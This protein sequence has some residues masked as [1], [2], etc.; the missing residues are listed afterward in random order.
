MAIIRAI[1]K[2]MII[3]Y[4]LCSTIS[5]KYST[6]P[7]KIVID[8][9]P[10]GDD[11]LAIMLAVM[12]EAQ[13]REIEILAITGT[14][15]NT[16][17]ENVENNL[18]KILTVANKKVPVYIGSKKPLIN[19]YE[20][21]YYFGKDGFGDFNFT[22]KITAKVDRSKHAS[23]ALVDLVKQYPGEITV[24]TLGPLTTIATAI[25]LEPNFLHLTKQHIM[26]GANIKRNEAEFNF[27]QDPE[28]DWIVLNNTNK[29][30]IILPIETVHSHAFS[31]D[32]YRSLCSSMDNSIAS[33]LYQAERKALEKQNNTWLPADGIT[34]AIALQPDIIMRSFKTNLT[35]VLVG[36]A[37]GS[38]VANSDSQ[39]HN[40][41]IIEYFDKAAFKRLILKLL[42]K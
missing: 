12:H 8:T 21:E 1:S 18:L 24:V 40:A 36:D 22:E 5:Q 15:G 13:T 29:P 11:A 32:E 27:K 6:T 10:G 39:I 7:R 34:M 41:K 2:I 14:Y 37:R 42:S 28:S 4:V 23:V 16:N 35:P 9:D 25:A 26:M 30:S 19:E 17:I 3:L 20:D 38:V 31:K 33:F